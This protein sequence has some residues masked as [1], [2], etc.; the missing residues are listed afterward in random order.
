MSVIITF[1][2]VAFSYTSSPLYNQLSWELPMGSICGL[3]GRNGEGKSTL[4]KLI[5]GILL[6]QKGKIQVLGKEPRKRSVPFLQEVFMVPEEMKFPALSIRQYFR[7]IG[8]FYP[9]Y[10][11]SLAYSL[12]DDFG[13]DK[14]MNLHK[15]SYGQKKKALIAL[16]IALQVRVLLMDEPT[17]GLDIP[18]KSLFRRI[19]ARHISPEQ[20][21]LISTHQVRDLEQIIDRIV[22]LDQNKIV[23]NEEVSALADLLTFDI[24]SSSN[25]QHCIYQEPSLIG[26]VGVFPQTDE[27]D[28]ETDFSMELFFNAMIE[29]PHE[30][31]QLL[32]TIQPLH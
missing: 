13:L 1:E 23:C 5:S 22:M 32:S 30:M 19:L 7:I 26:N 20:T 27:F 10:S 24:V 11:E 17:N 18:A 6:P 21:V 16:S 2:D 31:K 25:R 28:R 15:V 29:K 3:L 14:K 8:Q 4:F 9:T 12:L